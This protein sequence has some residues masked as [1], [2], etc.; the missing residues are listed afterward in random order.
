[1]CGGGGAEKQT[2]S[3]RRCV[4]RRQRLEGGVEGRKLE[5]R[6]GGNFTQGPGV[7]RRERAGKI[8]LESGGLGPRERAVE[9]AWRPGR[10]PR[11]DF[12]LAAGH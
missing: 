4:L 7:H 9:G 8:A 10:I 6:K 5:K 2:G 1:M 11:I 3:G 12:N